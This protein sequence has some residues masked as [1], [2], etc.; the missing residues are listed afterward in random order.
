MYS[1]MDEGRSQAM[2]NTLDR[3]MGRRIRIFVWWQ[4]DRQTDRRRHTK[5]T[6][7][8]TDADRRTQTQTDRIFVYSHNRKFVYSYVRNSY[9]RM[10]A[11][12]SQTRSTA[13]WVGGYSCIR[14]F[15]ILIFVYSY[16]GIRIFVNSFIRTFVWWHGAVKHARP[17]NGSAD[18]ASIKSTILFKIT[19]STKQINLHTMDFLLTK[20]IPS[21]KL[22]P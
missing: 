3:R 5:Q 21:Y 16:G 11:W 12:G 15:V 20:Q 22:A 9:I 4:A 2:S 1:T 10:V 19:I 7:R 8:Q 13:E 18:I 14:I 6:D 17:Q